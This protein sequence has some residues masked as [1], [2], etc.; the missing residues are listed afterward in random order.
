MTE[1]AAKLLRQVQNGAYEVY[2]TEDHDCKLVKVDMGGEP[3]A[4]ITMYHYTYTISVD[5]G[6][7]DE[8]VPYNQEPAWAIHKEL[9][10][11]VWD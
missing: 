2:P 1:K 5:Y 6:N 3:F 4:I 9:E 11:V 8:L 10:E 7:G